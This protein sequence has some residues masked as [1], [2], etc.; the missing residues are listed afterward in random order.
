MKHL[1]QN[2][3]AYSIHLKVNMNHYIYVNNDPTASQQNM[4]KLPISNIFSFS[5]CHWHRWLS[6]LLNISANFRKNSR[7]P[8]WYT[9]GELIHEKNLKSKIWCQTPFK[10]IKITFLRHYEWYCSISTIKG[11][12]QWELRWVKIGINRFIMM[13]SLASKF[14]LPCPKGHHHER[15]INVFS[16]FSTFWRHP[17]LLGQ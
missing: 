15:S 12:V 9:Q 2:Q 11:T 13:Y 3:L 16:G 1:Q 5:R 14:P 7:W 4:K 8:P 6:L 17:N 10:E